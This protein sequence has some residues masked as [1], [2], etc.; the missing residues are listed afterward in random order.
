VK[1][2]DIILERHFKPLEIHL[3]KDQYIGF[4]VGSA[5]L[6]GSALIT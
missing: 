4:N 2:E 1:A 3:L 6:L 5:I